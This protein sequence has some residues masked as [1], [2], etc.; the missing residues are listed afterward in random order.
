MPVA[1]DPLQRRLAGLPF[2]E[3][4]G[5]TEKV[6]TR[7]FRAIGRKLQSSQ[8]LIIVD[9]A[10][11]LDTKALEQ[12]RA[13]HD[14]FGLGIAL[15]G[16]EKVYARLEGGKRE[17]EFAQLFSR[18]GFRITQ[19]KPKPGDICSLLAAWGIT[20]KEELRF[21]KA[22]A[23]KPGALRVLTKT[24]QVASVQAAGAGQDRALAH[25]KSA[26]EQLEKSTA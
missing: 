7:F 23:G 22:I 26:Y 8:A 4:I 9:E 6:Q 24:L 18:V 21:C 25:I 20:D 11:H 15:I 1:L 12:L 17:A 19:A 10:Q 2:A 16:N 3:E 13:F 5:L 14:I